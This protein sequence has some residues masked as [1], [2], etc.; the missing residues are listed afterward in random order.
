M[1]S[2]NMVGLTIEKNEKIWTQNQMV[3]DIITPPL[4]TYQITQERK[5]KKWKELHRL[6]QSAGVIE[7][8]DCFSVEE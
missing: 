3:M 2:S 5:K 6:S 1:I 7:Y 4:K 8:T